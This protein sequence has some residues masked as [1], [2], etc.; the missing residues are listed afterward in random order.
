EPDEHGGGGARPGRPRRRVRLRDPPLGR[1]VG[2]VLLDPRAAADLRGAQAAGGR[3]SRRG[4]RRRPW[5]A[6]PPRVR[7]HSGGGGGAAQL[8]RGRRGRRAR[9]PRPR[10]A[11]AVLRRRGR[12]RRRPAAGRR[13]APSL[14]ALARAVPPGDHARRR[15]R[16]GDRRGVPRPRRGVRPRV[17]RVHHRL[18]RADGRD[19]RVRGRTHV[20]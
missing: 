16:A 5:R 1:A 14:R 17:P 18:V 11:A 19:P 20:M 15:T 13:H 6:R 12:A 8:V 10:A 3:R 2:A 7:G 4:P 9:A